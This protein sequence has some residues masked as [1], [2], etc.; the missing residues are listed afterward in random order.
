MGPDYRYLVEKAGIE[1][2]LIGFYDVP[3]ARAFEPLVRPPEGR[4]ACLF[5]FYPNWLKGESLHLTK[6]NYHPLHP[7]AVLLL[8]HLKILTDRRP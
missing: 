3:D 6:E 8:P 2:P 4:W 7:D 5:M 1:L